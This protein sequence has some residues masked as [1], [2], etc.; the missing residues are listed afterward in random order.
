[1]SV[2][3]ELKT[4]D[5]KFWVD[6]FELKNGGIKVFRRKNVSNKFYARFTF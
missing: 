3:E 2:E 5:H 1:M 6:Y 4:V